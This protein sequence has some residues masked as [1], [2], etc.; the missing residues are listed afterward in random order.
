MNR[1][2]ENDQNN[3]ISVD[4]GTSIQGRVMHHG[5]WENKNPD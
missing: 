1:I 4:S 5:G 2:L 3:E